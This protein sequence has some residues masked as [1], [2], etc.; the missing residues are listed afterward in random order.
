[1]AVGVELVVETKDGCF[2]LI[3]EAVGS[4]SEKDSHAGSSLVT[5]CGEAFVSVLRREKEWREKWCYSP[6]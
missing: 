4:S 2:T 3:D 5:A 6:R 1:M